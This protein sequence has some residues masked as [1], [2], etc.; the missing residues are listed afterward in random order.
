MIW[1]LV[2]VAG[3]LPEEKKYITIT[4]EQTPFATHFSGKQFSFQ[5]FYWQSRN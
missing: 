3:T 1:L 4:A 5:V 2:L